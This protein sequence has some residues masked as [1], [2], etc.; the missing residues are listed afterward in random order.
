MLRVIGVDRITGKPRSTRVKTDSERRAWLCAEARG[1][2]PRKVIRLS[3]RTA[4][5][6]K[7]DRKG[8]V[9]LLRS[10]KYFKIGKSVNAERRYG[11]LRIQLPEKPVLVHEILTNDVDYCERHWH[12]RFASQRANGEWFSLSEEDVTEFS[13]C[14]RMIVARV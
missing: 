9:Y 5:P 4:P 6:R 12:K 1:I 3:K 7:P 2:S 11:E 13:R 10:G 8:V 14:K